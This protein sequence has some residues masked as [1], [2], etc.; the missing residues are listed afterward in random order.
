MR[1]RGGRLVEFVAPRPSMELRL[2]SIR[3]SLAGGASINGIKDRGN[4][5]TRGHSGGAWSTRSYADYVLVID[6]AG[7]CGAHNFTYRVDRQYIYET[8]GGDLHRAVCRLASFFVFM[9]G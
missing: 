8:M 1:V 5:R 3:W 2:S 4:E 6:K 9:V 7:I